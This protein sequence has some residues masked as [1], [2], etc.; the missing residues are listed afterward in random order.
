[1]TEDKSSS[2]D[3]MERQTTGEDR[4]RTAIMDRR[5]RLQRHS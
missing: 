3:L 2:K 4:V 5:H 1:M